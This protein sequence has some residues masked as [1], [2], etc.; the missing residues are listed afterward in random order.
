[1]MKFSVK[2]SRLNYSSR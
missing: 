1:M 2:M